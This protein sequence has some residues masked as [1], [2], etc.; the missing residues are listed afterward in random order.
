MTKETINRCNEIVENYINEKAIEPI[1]RAIAILKG[2]VSPSDFDELLDTLEDAN[3]WVNMCAG[4]D[5]ELYNQY[6]FKL[7][8]KD[9]EYYLAQGDEITE[10]NPRHE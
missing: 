6:R 7:F 9:G 5:E 3:S 4:E 8:K 2:Q 10:I 1:G